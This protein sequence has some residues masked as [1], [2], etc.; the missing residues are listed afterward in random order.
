MAGKVRI[1]PLDRRDQPER[2]GVHLIDLRIK[3]R[4]AGLFV[5]T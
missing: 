1:R 3:W 4:N 5:D 2:H